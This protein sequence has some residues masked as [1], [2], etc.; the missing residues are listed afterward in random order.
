VAT[1]DPM[2]MNKLFGMALGLASPWQIAELKFDPEKTRLDIEIDFV[3]G[4]TFPCP[5]CNESCKVHDT[6]KQTWRHLNF[7]QHMAYL[8]ARQPRTKCVKHGVKTTTV[9]WARP[10]ANFT[11][12]FEAMVL[13]MGRNGM[14]P[15][16][17][18]RIVG[19]HDTLVW[20]I[21]E[22][23]VDEAR[24]RDSHAATTAVGVD[25]TA[26]E[27]GHVYVTL[28][29]DMAAA[30]VLTV[31][32]GKD[33]KTVEQFRSDF[34]EHGGQPEKVTD[35]SLDMSAAF[36]KGIREFFPLAQLTFDKFH[37]ISLMNNA[38][39]EVR[40]EE[41]KTRPELKKTRS[42]WLTNEENMTPDVR[43]R[44]Q[45]LKDSTLVTAR[46]WRI[47]TML[48]DLYRE[49]PANAEGFFQR[50]HFWATH[51]R[52]APV[53]RVARTLKAHQSGVLRWF[54][55]GINNGLLEGFNSLVQAAKAR[56]RGFRSPKKM[57]TI[58]YLLLAK[59][60]FKLPA[61]FPTA[62]HAR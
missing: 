53:I 59:L 44:F 30:R 50:W 34:V 35:F 54:A 42:S 26:R 16:A 9:P 6:T 57:A 58:I 19:E 22:H 56:S 21:L 32:E 46:A 52:L 33:H 38:V 11:L 24:A 20:R 60:D 5:E 18:S 17:I 36:I 8:H 29:V 61:P 45:T 51:C 13:A 28:F 41:A 3:P 31:A 37:V 10:G 7:F 1:S 25:E 43:A 15:K 4:S 48:Q 23:Y 14:T 47:K 2:E 27:K 40:R 39:T 49:L 12:L 55:S 62:A